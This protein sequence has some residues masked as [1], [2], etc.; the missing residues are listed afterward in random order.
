MTDIFLTCYNSGTAASH[1]RHNWVW[2]VYGLYFNEQAVNNCQCGLY[3][4]ELFNTIVL[5]DKPI[6]IVIYVFR[7][8]VCC[9]KDAVCCKSSLAFFNWCEWRSLLK[10]KTPQEVEGPTSH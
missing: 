7:N 9:I 4:A 2:G 8:T 10:A 6:F 3:T 5:P 1:M